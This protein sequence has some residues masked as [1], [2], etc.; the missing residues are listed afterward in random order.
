MVFWTAFYLIL[1]TEIGDKSRV[2]GLLLSTT[3]RAP[4][5]V[6]WG[7]TLG[8]GLLEGI[9][10]ALGGIV[11]EV[12]P[13]QWIQ[14]G[15]GVLFILLGVVTLLWA[16]EAEE[17]ATRWL[18]KLKKWGPFLVSFAAIGLS[19]IGDRTQI[20]VLTLSAQTEQPWSVFGGA[21]S[22]MVIL[23]AVTVWLGD[24]MTKRLSMRTIHRASAVLFIMLGIVLL[25]RSLIWK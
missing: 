12:V 24:R 8:Y 23:N 1:F 18:G 20:A 21:M 3:F 25:T 10:V 9:A 22:A 15:T 6:F 17:H 11:G 16:E 4:W 13:R 7:M 19:E 2:A 5:A 14:I